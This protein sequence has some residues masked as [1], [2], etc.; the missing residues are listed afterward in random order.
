FS[1]RATSTRGSRLA[2]FSIIEVSVEDQSTIT[3]CE[4]PRML[5]HVSKAASS[6]SA[7]SLMAVIND[8]RFVAYSVSGAS[9]T[10][11]SPRPFPRRPGR[12][13]DPVPRSSEGGGV[14]AATLGRVS[15]QRGRDTGDGARG[16]GGASGASST[17]SLSWVTWAERADHH[18]WIACLDWA[19]MFST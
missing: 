12:A 2:T 15:I 14:V 3:I 4:I 9:S 13:D 18:S 7:R 10:H 6:D 11:T 5:I 19:W 1:T 8:I 17:N 16:E